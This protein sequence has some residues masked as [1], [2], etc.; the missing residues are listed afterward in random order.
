[1]FLKHVIRKIIQIISISLFTCILL[2][3]SQQFNV[4]IGKLKFKYRVFYTKDKN[5]LGLLKKKIKNFPIF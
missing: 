5:R 3:L 1:M 4:M 2:I